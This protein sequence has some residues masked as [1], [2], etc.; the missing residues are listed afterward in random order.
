MNKHQSV[1]VC[2]DT[3]SRINEVT[4]WNKGD[5]VEQWKPDCLYWN[6]PT[7]TVERI[8]RC[9]GDK[10]K[11]EDLRCVNVILLAKYYLKN[12]Y[13]YP[14]WRFFCLWEA[15]C[16][17][18]AKLRSQ[19]LHVR[20]SSKNEGKTS[21]NSIL[22]SPRRVITQSIKLLFLSVRLIFASRMIFENIV[23]HSVKFPIPVDVTSFKKLHA[24]ENLLCCRELRNKFRINFFNVEF[25]GRSCRFFSV[26]H[27][28]DVT[29]E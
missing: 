15:N 2:S 1:A 29:V 13:A 4:I 25:G 7:Y 6:C 20:A 16:F 26:G 11:I 27:R 3:G 5:C 23:T 14:K 10:N 9:F 28:D 12:V 8:Y 18:Q 22:N 19:T 17:G 21:L 24:K